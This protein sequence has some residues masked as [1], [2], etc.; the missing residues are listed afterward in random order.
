MLYLGLNISLLAL[1]FFTKGLTLVFSTFFTS[2]TLLLITVFP[3]PPIRFSPNSPIVSTLLFYRHLSYYYQYSYSQI[4]FLSSPIPFI[5]PRSEQ[6]LFFSHPQRWTHDLNTLSL[7][8]QPLPLS[9]TCIK[10]NLVHIHTYPFQLLLC[11]LL[12]PTPFASRLH[13]FYLLQ[14]L[15][16]RI[17]HINLDK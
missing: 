16:H 8:I 4:L 12:Y 10:K 3:L 1:F 2:L 17:H 5:F 6:S 7:S 13:S 14:H 11:W 15:I 9:P